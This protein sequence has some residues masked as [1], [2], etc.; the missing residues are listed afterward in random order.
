VDEGT[1]LALAGRLGRDPFGPPLHVVLRPAGTLEAERRLLGLVGGGSLRLRVETAPRLAAAAL[2][3]AGQSLRPLARRQ[4]V[5]LVRVAARQGGLLAPFGDAALRHEAAE[6]L[7]ARSVEALLGQ[8]PRLPE[9]AEAVLGRGVYEALRR[10]QDDV[11][12]LAEAQ[13]LLPEPLLYWRAADALA[14]GSPWPQG[15][16]YWPEDDLEPAQSALRRRLGELGLL[17]A[18]DGPDEPDGPRTGVELVLRSAAAPEQEARL[19]A[20]R[21]LELCAAGASP[22]DIVIG[23]GDLQGERDLVR[24]ALAQAGI[25][26]DA[27]R[28]DVRGEPFVLSVRAILRLLR[29]DPPGAA[30]DLLDAGLVPPPGPLRDALVAELR[31]GCPGDAAARFTGRLAAAAA[32]WPGAAPLGE[33]RQLLGRLMDD[34]GAGTV[35]E[36]PELAR[37]AALRDAYVEQSLA[38]EAFLGQRRITRDLAVRLLAD[39]LLA[40][41]AEHLPH[42]GTVRILPILDVGDVEADHVLLLSAAE[43]TLPATAREGGILTEEQLHACAAAGVPLEESA[44][45]ALRRGRR[46]ARSALG[47]ARLS[48]YASCAQLDAQGRAQMPAFAL[49]RLGEP[50]APPLPAAPEEVFARALSRREAGELLAEAVSRRRDIG[51]E[52]AAAR[53]QLRAWAAVGGEGPEL[54]G[55]RPPREEPDGPAARGPFSVTSLERRA[56]CPFVSFAHD[57]VRAGPPERG[58]FD[59]PTRGALVHRVL[60]EL[61]LAAPPQAERA[62]VVS[63]C[64]DRAADALGALPADAAG[65]RALRR[66]VAA[67]VLRTAEMIWAEQARSAFRVDGRELGFGTGQA[68]SPLRAGEAEVEGRIDRVDV[69]DGRLR[70]IDYKVRRGQ[71]FSVARVLHG[72]D[73]QVGAYALAAAQ[74]LGLQP[75]AMLYWPVRFGQTW[76]NGAEA[77]DAEDDWHAQRPKGLYL[78]D[79]DLLAL[80]DRAAPDGDSPFHPLRRRRDGQLV[81]SPWTLPPAA[82]AE[83]LRR[84]AALLAELAQ[85][86]AQGRWGPSP[87][88]L[89]RETACQGCRLRAACRFEPQRDGYRTLAAWTKEVL[90]LAHPDD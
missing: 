64:V 32:A 58:G 39:A 33:H 53:A 37:Q 56:A 49:R 80:L 17:L 59:P 61:P 60:S 8:A 68:L 7:L 57:L 90:A 12:A 34:L 76:E 23:L 54:A 29:A 72:L 69:A 51:L 75:V 20:R 1:L 5:S 11:L 81:R 50:M 48:L 63:A 25:A 30:L 78:D 65:G 14:Q 71:T 42:Q 47:A 46:R 31:D 38:L 45:A 24:A 35:L 19:A 43:G 4:F 26:V 2:E 28:P 55:L 77:G 36:H 62:E 70:V 15:C 82:W 85:D 88:R 22:G 13:G 6:E 40:V 83:L 52:D 16:V 87:Y 86:A 84:V 9:R 74:A 89:G 67:G 21:C 41:E 66:G 10:A 73:L 3:A 27:G 79:P 18:L 44:A